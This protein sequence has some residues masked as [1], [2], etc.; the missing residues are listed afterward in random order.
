METIGSVIDQLTVVNLKLYHI[1]DQARDEAITGNKLKEL[2]RK[3]NDLNVQRSMLKD[4]I[5][6]MLNEA[7]KSGKVPMMFS[8]KQYGKEQQ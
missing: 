5:D 6:S 4:Q 2:N 7:V 8:H 1:E 3:R